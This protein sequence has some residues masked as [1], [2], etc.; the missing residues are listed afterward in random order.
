MR[1]TGGPKRLHELAA[2]AG[3]MESHGVVKPRKANGTRW[4]QYKVAALAA[5][6]EA[7]VVKSR[8]AHGTRWVQHK[9]AAA[10]AILMSYDVL[11]A[12]LE[13]MS[14]DPTYDQAKAKGTFSKVNTFNFVCLLLSSSTCSCQ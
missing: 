1:Q 5:A 11:T 2:L 7:H 10:T 8:K 12:H 14:A 13:S 9:V 4:L 3:A 6:L